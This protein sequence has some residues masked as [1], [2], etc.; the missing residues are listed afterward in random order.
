M[1][2]VV[3]FIDCGSL[4]ISYDVTGKASVSLTILRSDRNELQE[5][6][7]NRRWGGVQFDCVIMNLGQRP[8]LGT[9]GWS[10]WSMQMEGVGN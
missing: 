2:E 10:E 7:T 3:E 5:T 9:G 8:I 4:S 1:A 6:Y